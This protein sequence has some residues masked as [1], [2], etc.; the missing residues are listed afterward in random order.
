[1]TDAVV[2]ST[3]A[4]RF[5]HLNPRHHSIALI[6]MEG[7]IGLHHVMMECRDLDDVGVAH[8]IV[9][10]RE[11]LPLA[12]TLGRHSTDRMVSFYVQT[13]SGFEIEYGWGGKEL[14][15]DNWVTTE[16]PFPAETWGHRYVGAGVPGTIRAIASRARVG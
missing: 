11:D 3:G 16:S 14:D 2:T 10:G 9:L 6:E 7:M 8:D 4:A 15:V 12:L 1:L 13:P 5:Y